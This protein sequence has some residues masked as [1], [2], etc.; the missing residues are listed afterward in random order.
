MNETVNQPKQTLSSEEER[1][2]QGLP[3]NDEPLTDEEIR[4]LEEHF[5]RVRAQ[6][7]LAAKEAGRSD[8]PLLL[9]A[10]KTVEPRRINYAI[11]H[12]GLTDIGE[13]R[14]Q[15]LLEKYPYYDKSARLHFIGTLQKNKVKYIVD[16]VCLIHSVDSVALGQVI[17]KQALKKDVHVDVLL[18][19]NTGREPQKSGFLPEELPQALEAFSAFSRVHVKGLMAVAPICEK[20]S[21]YL[22]Y[23]G[24]TSQIFID[25]SR[26]KRHNIDMAVLSMGMSDSLAPAV[27]SGSTLLRIGSALFGKRSYAQN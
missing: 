1:P 14:V 4:E 3:S 13:N 12:L 23:F 20:N 15:E 26:K 17:E 7:A 8:A 22:R 11:R 10:T 9:A 2:L 25:F 21:D 5:A 27:A 24:E 16:K 19:I 6:I 18:Q